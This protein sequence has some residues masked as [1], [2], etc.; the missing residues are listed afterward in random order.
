MLA[1]FAEKYVIDG[2]P[3]LIPKEYFAKIATQIKDFLRNHR[4]SKVRMILVCLME[5]RYVEKSIGSSKIKSDEDIVYF[6]S[7]THVNLEKT[8]VKVILKEM[9]I[10]I[11]ET[12]ITYQKKG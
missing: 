8:D 7:R 6:H 1:N 12:L 11:L 2:I 9:I 10:Q 5:R 4:N 3:G